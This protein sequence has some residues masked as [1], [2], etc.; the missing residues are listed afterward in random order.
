MKA[1]INEVPN[2]QVFA[3]TEKYLLDILKAGGAGCISATAN[4]TIGLAAQIF[5]AWKSGEAVE[6]LQAYLV[7]VRTSFEGL[8]FSGA[9]KTFLAD[10]RVNKEWLPIRPPNERLDQQRLNDLKAALIALDFDA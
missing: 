9:L 1:L 4:V 5:Q 6:D 8:P 2:F 7:K 3:G 10:L